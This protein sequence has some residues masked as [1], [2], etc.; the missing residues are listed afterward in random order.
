MSSPVGIAFLG[1]SGSNNSLSSAFASSGVNAFLLLLVP[2][3]ALFFSFLE[4]ANM[5]IFRN[6]TPDD[7]ERLCFLPAITSFVYP[8]EG[9][10]F[11]VS[12]DSTKDYLFGQIGA[13]LKLSLIKSESSFNKRRKVKEVRFVDGLNTTFR[14]IPAVYNKSTTSRL[15]GWTA[16]EAYSFWQERY[17]C[18]CWKCKDMCDWWFSLGFSWSWDTKYPLGSS[19]LL[20]VGDAVSVASKFFLFLFYS[21]WLFTNISY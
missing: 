16:G 6:Y 19:T 12:Y 10:F 1:I 3:L 9:A 15:R 4:V 2:P 5:S 14:G 17:R 13:R 8:D 7:V 21:Y 20:L 18:L 11:S